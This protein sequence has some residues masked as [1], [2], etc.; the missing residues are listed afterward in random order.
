MEKENDY[1]CTLLIQH[2]QFAFISIHVRH[3]QYIKKNKTIWSTYSII[4][5]HTFWYSA[6]HTNGF[7]HSWWALVIHY[8]PPIYCL[9][10]GR[11]L[12]FWVEGIC[13]V[14]SNLRFELWMAAIYTSHTN[15]WGCPQAYSASSRTH[16]L[17]LQSNCG[18]GSSFAYSSSGLSQ[19]RKLEG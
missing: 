17:R 12:N 1:N 9:F 2:L 7:D 11:E 8:Q 13:A 19:R 4:F 14:K 10:Q 16:S 15:N 3:Q 5:I 18:W 6:N